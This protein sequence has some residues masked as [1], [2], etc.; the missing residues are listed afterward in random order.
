M[1]VHR[2]VHL[3]IAARDLFEEEVGAIGSGSKAR[4]APEPFVTMLDVGL[5]PR[6]LIVDRSEV[7]AQAEP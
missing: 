4:D 7:P 2:Q 5:D 1:N 6:F 3:P